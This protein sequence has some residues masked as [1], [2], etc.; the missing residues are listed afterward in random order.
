MIGIVRCIHPKHHSCAPAVAHCD[1]LKVV[2]ACNF[3]VCPA[4]VFNFRPG[5]QIID[6]AEAFDVGP[7]EPFV[8][9]E[10]EGEMSKCDIVGSSDIDSDI[11]NVCAEWLPPFLAP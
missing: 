2:V 9:P 6:A 7:E 1:I 4:T 8:G 3:L 5:K 11:R 10:P